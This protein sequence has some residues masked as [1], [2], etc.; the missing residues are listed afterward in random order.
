MAYEEKKGNIEDLTEDMEQKGIQVKTMDGDTHIIMTNAEM[1]ECINV[2][3]EL[4]ETGRLGYAIARNKRKLMDAAKEF[5]ELRDDLLQK[6]G[7][8]EDG[9]YYSVSPEN[10]DAYI[11]ELG[12]IPQIAHEVEIFTI[13]EDV[14]FGGSLK[15]NQ[16]EKLLWMVK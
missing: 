1:C 3:S 12:D 2:L 4:R 6:Y 15:S 14:F 8:S 11:K 5:L 9:I 10:S 13:P 16:M 7:E